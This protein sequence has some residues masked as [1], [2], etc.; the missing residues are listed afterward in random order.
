M[1]LNKK[2]IAIVGGLLVVAPIILSQ[3]IRLPFGFLTIG[4]ENSWVGFFGG[5]IG[6]ITGA[7][8]AFIVARYQI[9][10]Q[11]QKQ[12]A[13]EEM[14]SFMNQKP[15]LLKIKYEL[16]AMEDSLKN[17]GRI[18]GGE[19]STEFGFEMHEMS[20]IFWSDIDRVEDTDLSTSLITIS[21]TYKSLYK[22]FSTDLGYL[23]SLKD[24]LL[25]E[26]LE[27]SPE[28]YEKVH[29]AMTMD[30]QIEKMTEE[31]EQIIFNRNIPNLTNDIKNVID[32]VDIIIASIDE[33]KAERQR[34]RDSTL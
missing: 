20:E 30:E 24:Q 11:F 22:N 12:V 10:T 1:K 31:R 33:N 25:R 9:T 32:V 5:Y 7:V 8:V 27:R 17:L 29:R 34:I 2:N 26:F 23:T 21:N 18:V 19:T 14:I 6:A 3:L 15:A 4:D 13:N 16:I 28:D